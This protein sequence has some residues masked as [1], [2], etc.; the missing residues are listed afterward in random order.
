MSDEWTV[1][2]WKARAQRDPVMDTVAIAISRPVPGGREVVTSF[3][4]APDGAFGPQ[5]RTFEAGTAVPWSTLPTLP[6]ELAAALLRGLEGY[7]HGSDAPAALSRRDFDHE[8]GRVDK[9]TDAL[10]T[11]V[12][13]GG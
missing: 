8:R 1:A 3:D 7:F 5:T 11:F 9:L 6:E 10:I 4:R 2:G 12:T 13:K